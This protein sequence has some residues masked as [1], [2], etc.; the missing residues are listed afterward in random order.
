[1]EKNLNRGYLFKILSTIRYLARQGISLKRDGDE[2]DSNLYQLLV[3]RGEE[4]SCIKPMLENTQ[5]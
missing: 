2:N 1:M 4:N 5:L 3:L